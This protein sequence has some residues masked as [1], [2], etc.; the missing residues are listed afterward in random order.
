MHSKWLKKLKKNEG[1]KWS[2]KSKLI[3]KETIVVRMTKENER[4][5]CPPSGMKGG[6]L[7]RFCSYNHVWRVSHPMSMGTL[8]TPTLN[9]RDGH[10]LMAWGEGF[11]EAGSVVFELGGERLLPLEDM[12]VL[13]TP[14]AQ[15]GMETPPGDQQEQHLVS[16]MEP[17]PREKPVVVRPSRPCGVRP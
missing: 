4:H 11:W 3:L 17:P 12:M 14:Q 7:D 1:K 15:V 10:R 9:R 5:K 8:K 13:M 2:M 16:W 6:R